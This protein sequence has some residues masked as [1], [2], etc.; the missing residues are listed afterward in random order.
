LPHT[1]PSA[2]S[3]LLRTRISASGTNIYDSQN[4]KTYTNP[5]GP[6]RIFAFMRYANRIESTKLCG[7][8]VLSRVESGSENVCML[9]LD[10]NPDPYLIFSGSGSENGRILPISFGSSFENFLC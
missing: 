9:G 1:S 10:P 7:F 5:S 8:R 3:L 2:S 6:L 4:G